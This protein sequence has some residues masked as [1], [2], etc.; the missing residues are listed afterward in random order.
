MYALLRNEQMHSILAWS[1]GSE[2]SCNY[3]LHIY[4]YNNT[5][6]RAHYACI[7]CIII[8]SRCRRLHD[9]SHY[10]YYWFDCISKQALASTAETRYLLFIIHW[11]YWRHWER[12]VWILRFLYVGG[13]IRT[14]W[15]LFIS[16]TSR[17]Q[18]CVVNKMIR[19]VS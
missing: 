10:Y 17:V 12:L 3:T 18:Y 19:N 9:Y 7:L 1:L 8:N 11:Q 4:L 16:K 15:K 14:E 13:R 2:S 5:Y 6:V